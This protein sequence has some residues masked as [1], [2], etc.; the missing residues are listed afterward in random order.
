MLAFGVLAESVLAA[1]PLRASAPPPPPPPPAST[2]GGAFLL[3]VGL[4]RSR[5]E[6]PGDILAIE[7]R[8]VPG[9]ATAGK[10]VHA[11]AMNLPRAEC[12]LVCGI[13]SGEDN[14]FCDEEVQAL[15]LVLDDL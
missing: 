10:S 11:I 4:R 15:A 9:T 12:V 7:L 5:N 8:L 1:I 13:A 2:V 14:L 3:P 6:A